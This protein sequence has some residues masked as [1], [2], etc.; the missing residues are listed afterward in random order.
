MKFSGEKL[1][2]H[3]FNIYVEFPKLKFMKKNLKENEIII[4]IGIF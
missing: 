1:R 3:F 2:R 4:T